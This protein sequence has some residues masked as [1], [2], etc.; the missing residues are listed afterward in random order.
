[1]RRT[2]VSLSLV[3]AAALGGPAVEFR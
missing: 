3:R 1:M 2:A